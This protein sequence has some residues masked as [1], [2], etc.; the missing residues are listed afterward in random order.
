MET[1]EYTHNHPI[2]ENLTDL[3]KKNPHLKTTEAAIF[4]VNGDTGLGSQLTQFIQNA[5]FLYHH[6]NP[7]LQCFP[8]FLNNTKH[9]KYHDERWR[10]KNTFFMYFRA[11]AQPRPTDHIYFVH[12]RVYVYFPFFSYITP[13]TALEHNAKMLQFFNERFVPRIG[14]NIRTYIGE[15]RANEKKP[16]VGIHIRS[17]FQKKHHKENYLATP[18]YARLENVKRALDRKYGGGEFDEAGK[19]RAA[20]TL[21]VAT[22]TLLYIHFCAD[23]FG[24]DV[25]Q[26]IDGITRIESEEDSVPNLGAVAGFKLG[27]DILYDCLA[28]SLCDEIFVSNSNVPFIVNMLNMDVPM[29]EY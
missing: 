1:V 5:Y 26:Y 12:T 19:L 4:F 20:Y 17:A 22:D 9:F 23:I 28:L 2:H 29:T 15:I 7:R 16:L 27:A 24:A 10:G 18:I 11:T 6:Y 13:P 3:I 14:D 8:Y 21:F 25:V